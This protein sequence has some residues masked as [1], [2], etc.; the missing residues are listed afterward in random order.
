M[1]QGQARP[2][3]VNI[4]QTTKFMT[5]QTVI[6]I[7]SCY[8]FSEDQIANFRRDGFI[9]LKNV[10]TEAE[11]RHYE[12]EFTRLV[13][14]ETTKLPPLAERSDYEKAFVQVENLW[15]RSTFAR[16]F[17]FSRRFARMAAELLGVAGVRLYHDQALY[18]EAGGGTT[19]WHQDQSYFPLKT[20]NVVTIW[21]PLQETSREMGTLAFAKG[22]N[23]CA[24]KSADVITKEGAEKMLAFLNSQGCEVI[25][26]PFE[27]GEVSFHYGWTA[28]T[29]RPN[30]TDQLRKVMTIIYFEDGARVFAS[31]KPEHVVD[32]QLYLLDA[33][34]GK[35]ADS[36]LTPVL[37]RDQ[38]CRCGEPPFCGQ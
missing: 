8:L 11:I 3:E 26:E 9:H 28:H 38:G 35:V 29:A 25:E 27:L 5:L 1:K 22:S 32:R 21:I 24:Y 6:D 16:E 23:R 20:D 10:L 13:E 31:D 30:R 19:M 33:C 7:N 2:L 17:T 15:L 37:W 36:P 12:P 4:R 34:I 18:K 14:E